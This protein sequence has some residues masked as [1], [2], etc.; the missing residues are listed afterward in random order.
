MIVAPADGYFHPSGFRAANPGR[1]SLDIPNPEEWS[2]SN[3]SQLAEAMDLHSADSAPPEEPS[4]K[5][6][7]FFTPKRTEPTLYRKKR[8]LTTT[9]TLKLQNDWL[10]MR[11]PGLVKPVL[12]NT[13]TVHYYIPGD[14]FEVIPDDFEWLK[15]AS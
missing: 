3:R 5:V 1:S 11:N 9:H 7:S 10:K 4:Q 8:M 2:S 14:S 6:P 15:T 13:R 12:S